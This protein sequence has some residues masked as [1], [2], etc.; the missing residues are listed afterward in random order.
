MVRSLGIV[1][2]VVVAVWFFARPPHSDEKSIRVVDATEDVQAFAA[3]VRGVP[4]PR[5]LPSGW[6]TTVSRYDGESGLLR[7][8]WVTPAGH[9]AEYAA[10]AH[11]DDRFLGDITGEAPKGEPLTI[12]ATSWTPY[13]AQGALSLV[14]VFGTTTVVLGT[15]RDTATAEEL[16]VLARA[17]A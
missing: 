6:R 3:D 12:G 9:Y 13:R 8:G 5:S 14:H 1:M 11:P 15:V 10:A 7:V 2:L 4:V 16:R 17:L